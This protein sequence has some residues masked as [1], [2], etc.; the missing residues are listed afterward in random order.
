MAPLL[1]FDLDGTLVD[2]N[3]ACVE[4]LRGMLCSRGS[5]IEI[6]E[7]M[8][9]TYM[10]RGGRE[11]VRALLADAC[12]DPDAD[13]SE[14][15]ERYA[16]HTTSRETLFPG[17]ARGLEALAGAG[18]TM[19]ICSNKP[20]ALCEKVLIDTDLAQW[21]ETIVGS[22]PDLRA[23][24]EPDLLDCVLSAHR[25]ARGEG[26]FIGDSEIDHAVARG[27]GMPFHFLSWGYAEAGWMPSDGIVHHS[28]ETL[29]DQL[30]G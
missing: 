11:M 20:Q 18:F 5:A 28:F 14:F 1:V 23:K 22:R 7:R 4:I 16:S 21:F 8:A 27:A 24:P 13:L 2:S 15:R 3:A 19:A 25:L 26:V 10:S 9:S 30:S 17:V 29:V 6:D 12:A